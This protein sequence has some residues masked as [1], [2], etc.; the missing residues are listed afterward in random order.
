MIKGS[1]SFVVCGNIGPTRGFE[2]LIKNWQKCPNEVTLYIQGKDNDFKT[3][4]QNLKS[5]QN[6]IK[7]KSLFFPAA[8]REDEI[9]SSMKRYDVGIIPY[10][11]VC[12]NNKY[13]FPNKTS[14]YLKA[15]LPILANK[16]PAV[17]RILKGTD[18][19]FSFDFKNK[20]A[21]LSVIRYFAKEANLKKAK[22]AALVLHQH[23]ICWE[24]TSKAFYGSLEMTIGPTAPQK[25]HNLQSSK[26]SKYYFTNKLY[27]IIQN[28]KISANT[29]FVLPH[30]NSRQLLF[31][32]LCLFIAK[33]I[34]YFNCQ[35]LKNKPTKY[36]YKVLSGIR[37]LYLKLGVFKRYD[38]IAKKRLSPI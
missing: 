10:E 26:T 7:R 35:L 11:P 15:G 37:P 21:F 19:G 20:D 34:F 38:S 1:V 8:V 22:E 3:Y 14:Q 5:T 29:L 12:L 30:Y 25:K 27:K 32:L 28:E 13:C 33:V 24:E 6:L 16:L 23:K 36:P 18:A 31:S 2:Q 4:L 17:A 9:I